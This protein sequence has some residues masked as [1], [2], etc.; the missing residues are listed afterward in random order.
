MAI[1]ND[2][3]LLTV[4]CAFWGSLWPTALSIVVGKFGTSST[5][6][7]P[8]HV[9]SCITQ[10]TNGQTEEERGDFSAAGGRFPKY[11]GFSSLVAESMFSVN[12]PIR[13]KR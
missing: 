11:V 6:L 9:H 2:S 7:S 1:Q 8:V 5:L 3:V 12:H 4:L 13:S 10:V